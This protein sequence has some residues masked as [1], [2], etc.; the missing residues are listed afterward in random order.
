MP[1]ADNPVPEY[2]Y[3][4]GEIPVSLQ[5]LEQILGPRL[6]QIRYFEY[7]NLSSIASFRL[8]VFDGREHRVFIETIYR[9]GGRVTV[10]M[11]S[12][13]TREFMSRAAQAIGPI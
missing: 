9:Q 2:V 5:Q 13:E 10:S 8:S 6:K 3:Q 1:P 11:N 4:S 7:P 12:Q